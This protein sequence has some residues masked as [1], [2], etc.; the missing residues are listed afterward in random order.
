MNQP[1]QCI[2]RVRMQYPDF[3]QKEKMI[4]DY[5]LNSPENFI[6]KTIDQVAEELDVAISTVFRFTKTVGFKGFQAM[7]ITLASEISE[8]MK[9]LADEKIAEKD[10]EQAITEKIFNNNIRMFKET[11]DVMDFSSIK[12]SVNL[13][14]QANRVEFYGSES[15]SLVAQD[16][17]HKFIGSG[18]STS[19]YSDAH[20]QLKAAAQLTEQDVVIYLS[21]SG[22]NKESERVLETVKEQGAKIISITNSANGK[23]NKL[24]DIVLRTGSVGNAGTGDETDSFSRIVQL[25]LIDSLYMNVMGA[26]KKGKNPLGK[27]FKK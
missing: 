13:I 10:H 26:K 4:A 19:A 2:A 5:I 1:Q 9:E 23:L 25:S 21:S 8:S 16:A 3:S 22:L 15:S 7:K 6:H 12:K 27:L 11:I 14:M 20:I 24:S 17:H 18:I